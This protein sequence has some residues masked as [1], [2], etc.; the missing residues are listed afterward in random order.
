[1][2]HQFLHSQFAK[3]EHPL[4]SSLLGIGSGILTSAIIIAFKMGFE[5][6]TTLFLP[7]HQV[8]AFESLPPL[9]RFLLP[10]IGAILLGIVFQL[11]RLSSVRTGLAHCVYIVN[12]RHAMFPLKNTLTQFF[13]GIAA[14]A[15]GQS[16]GQEGPSVHLGAAGSAIAGQYL[17]A[18][19]NMLRILAGCGVAAAIATAF[20]TPLAGVVFAMEVVLLEY[21]ISGLIP[22]ILAAVTATFLR[23]FFLTDELSN[24]A[25]H[26]EI[27]Q[28]AEIGLIIL[29]SLAIA[30]TSSLFVIITRFW[31]RFERWPVLLRF[32]LAGAITGLAALAAPEVMGTGNDTIASLLHNQSLQALLIVIVLAKVMATGSAIGL[33]IPGG[34]IGPSLMLGAC[35]GALFAELSHSWLPD[36]AQSSAAYILLG[37][38][39]M[40]SAA[41]NAPLAALLF[42]VELSFNS[43]LLFPG[44]ILVIC[45]N[46]LHGSLFKQPSMVKLIF[47]QQGLSIS[48][49]AFSRVLAR[50]NIMQ[51]MNTNLA[52]IYRDENLPDDRSE[53]DYVLRVNDPQLWLAILGDKTE[54]QW[55]PTQQIATTASLLQA[56][57]LL[58]EKELDYLVCS[59][60]TKT[61]TLY[62]GIIS[63]Q[64]IEQEI[65]R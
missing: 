16:V 23:S 34:L 7:A 41:I 17:G 30:A 57:Q 12:K 40:M 56:W 53:I 11:L 22:V 8:E 20:N 4:V 58:N 48:D 18:P 45:S 13:G 55:Q 32:S 19:S 15:T 64:Q 9:A 3:R 36:V 63:R 31:L 44:L 21:S 10:F 52:V 24:L 62:I 47:D 50:R 35:I 27:I 29:M 14:L 59:R 2:I 61:T 37:M 39:A 28:N 6:P 46:L 25:T 1:M 54:P 65:H 42:V 49:S 51:T 60:K 33:G 26:T 38:A 43:Q 5:L